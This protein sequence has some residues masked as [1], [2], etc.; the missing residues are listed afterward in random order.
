M[1]FGTQKSK[2][3]EQIKDINNDTYYNGFRCGGVTCTYCLLYILNNNECIHRNELSNNK[4]LKIA[5]EGLAHA[6]KLTTPN[7][8]YESF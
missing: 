3:R 8:Q 6:H 4:I 1:Q 5:T 7:K 2:R